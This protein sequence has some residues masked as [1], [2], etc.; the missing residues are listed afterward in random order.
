MATARERRLEEEL[1]RLKTNTN[2]LLAGEVYEAIIKVADEECTLTMVLGGNKPCGKCVV[3]VIKAAERKLRERYVHAS[4]R[5]HSKSADTALEALREG[6]A[7]DAQQRAL[8]DL[9]DYMR[10]GFAGVHREDI[11]EMAKSGAEERLTVYLK[12]V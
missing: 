11:W 10:S 12:D 9:I 7:T 1:G 8:A 6:L 5:A 4:F 2:F 3:C